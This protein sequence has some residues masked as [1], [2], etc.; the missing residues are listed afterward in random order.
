[1][2]VKVELYDDGLVNEL[3]S[4]ISFFVM[5]R[6]VPFRRITRNP[7]GS[8][9]FVYEGTSEV[10]Y[11][12]VIYVQPVKMVQQSNDAM[13]TFFQY[14]GLFAKP[15]IVLSALSYVVVCEYDETDVVLGVIA[16]GFCSA[17]INDSGD[18]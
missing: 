4:S 8:F 1:M 9:L 17:S 15:L 12:D 3:K 14:I 7:I 5:H 18:G 16:N 2:F 10:V 6:L 13:A 11:E